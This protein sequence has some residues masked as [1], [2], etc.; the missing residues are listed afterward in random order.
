MPAWVN[1]I[2][3]SDKTDKDNIRVRSD[4]LKKYNVVELSP[5]C[6]LDKDISQAKNDLS[7]I[8]RLCEM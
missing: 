7:A 8:T 2:Q 6:I 1:E 3:Y 5:K 4:Y